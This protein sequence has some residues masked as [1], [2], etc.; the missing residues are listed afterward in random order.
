STK[1]L[2]NTAAVIDLAKGTV[3]YNAAKLGTYVLELTNIPK[4][5]KVVKA[6][7]TTGTAQVGRALTVSPGTYSVSGVTTTYQ[8]LRDG[9]PVMGATGATYTVAQADRNT[10]LSVRVTASK[11]GYTGVTTTSDPTAR[12]K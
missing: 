4:L 10:R 6:P 9:V 7:A 3:T 1:A 11:P 5:F 2:V 8:W 12:V